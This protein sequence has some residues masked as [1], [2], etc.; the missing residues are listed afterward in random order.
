MSSNTPPT[1]DAG[2]VERVRKYADDSDLQP[3]FQADIRALCDAV[4][5]REQCRVS[6]YD[7]AYE[8][9]AHNRMWGA[10]GKNNGPCHD[11]DGKV[12]NALTPLPTTPGGGESNVK[13]TIERPDAIIEIDEAGNVSIPDPRDAPNETTLNDVKVLRRAA[14]RI[15]DRDAE[16]EASNI[17]LGEREAELKQAEADYLEKHQ[18]CEQA[19][20]R[21]ERI[22]EELKENR[23]CMDDDWFARE[24]ARFRAKW[25]Q[26]E[27]ERDALKADLDKLRAVIHAHIGDCDNP[28]MLTLALAGA[29]E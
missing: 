14:A 2:V 19:E 29:S 28:I 5:K 25:K 13:E 27:R 4:E 16:I 23:A 22:E 1:L 17:L 6:Y 18:Q 3:Q 10:V 8:C 20:A 12:D 11:W 24:A 21:A 7:G 26:A 9:S 15:Q